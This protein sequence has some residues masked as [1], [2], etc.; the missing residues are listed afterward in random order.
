MKKSIIFLLLCTST[1]NVFSQFKITSNNKIGIGTAPDNNYAV[2]MNG[3]VFIKGYYNNT[4][5]RLWSGASSGG[6]F[7]DISP[8]SNTVGYSYLGYYNRWYMTNLSYLYVY[9][10]LTLFGNFYNYSDKNL[11]KDICQLSF[12]KDLFSQLK[13]VSYNMVDSLQMKK[14]NGENET[15]KFEKK[16]YPIKGFL[17]QD[18]QK[19]FPELVE[20]DTENGLLKIKTLEFIP[21]LVK[22]IQAQQEEIDAL[23]K[24]IN[25]FT[26]NPS[27]VRSSNISLFPDEISPAV[28][29]QNNPNP[30]SQSTQIKYYLPSTVQNAYLCIYDLQGK[31]LKQMSISERG[32]GSLLIS[33][34]EFVAGIYLYGLIIDG[35]EVDIKRM[36]LTN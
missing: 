16:E 35:N 30:F 7:V 21:I 10:N 27:K 25:N 4:Y 22:A 1:F 23:K 11:K 33:A 20:E 24:E 17:A 8:S 26:S 3:D 6:P 15:L 13:P 9:N 29:Y 14:K 2:T 31:Q 5:I 34:S 36:I 12:N 18:V 32:N 19:I 28:L